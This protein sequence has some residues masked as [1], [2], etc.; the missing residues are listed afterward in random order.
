MEKFD[1]L[2][3]LT[4]LRK[5]HLVCVFSESFGLELAQQ[6]SRSAT[7]LPRISETYLLLYFLVQSLIDFLNRFKTNFRDGDS[8]S[9]D[10]TPIFKPC[11]S[12]IK[13][14]LALGKFEDV[15]FAFS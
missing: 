13:K 2:L 3:L 4:N 9:I 15:L 5:Y 14:A 7:Q 6:K 8:F 12:F 11:A 10:Y 1:N